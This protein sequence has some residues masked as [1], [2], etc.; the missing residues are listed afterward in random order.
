MDKSKDEKKSFEDY[1]FKKGEARTY[2]CAYKGAMS[3]KETRDRRKTMREALNMILEH[4]D[5]EGVSGVE[6]LA[7]SAYNRACEGDP[8]AIKLIA[9]LIGEFSEK[10]EV[11]QTDNLPPLSMQD[12][13]ELKKLVPKE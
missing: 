2:E 3:A 12:I 6:R 10:V 4:K 9:Q 13:E 5:K 1:Q 7:L 8:Q 11:A